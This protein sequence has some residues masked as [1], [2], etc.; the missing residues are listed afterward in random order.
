MLS[1]FVILAITILASPQSTAP[2]QT[3]EVS[4]RDR[5]YE[6]V[7]T[8][9]IALASQE[10]EQQLKA[11]PHD[12]EIHLL[13]INLGM[14]LLRAGRRP[15]GE[16][17]FEKFVRYVF[18]NPEH[19][20]SLLK[21][22]P[23]I[24]MNITSVQ[25]GVEPVTSE[26]LQ[27]VIPLLQKG[28]VDQPTNSAFSI[29]LTSLTALKARLLAR[30]EQ[31]VE[32]LSLINS[33]LDR[34]RSRW[35]TD[36]E[37]PDSWLRLALMLRSAA[38]TIG[39]D[40]NSALAFSFERTNVLNTGVSKF[41][42][43]G[44]LIKEAFNERLAQIKQYE[45][46]SPATALTLYDEADS[47][48]RKISVDSP[49]KKT[50]HSLRIDI[51]KSRQKFFREST[52]KKLIGSRVFVPECDWLNKKPVLSNLET[53]LTAYFFFTAKQPESIQELIKF[54]DYLKTAYPDVSA[55][56]MTHSLDDSFGRL[57]IVNRT[58]TITDENAREYRQ[59]MID[60]IVEPNGIDFPVGLLADTLPVADHFGFRNVPIAFFFD[61]G[62]C[63]KIVQGKDLLKE[64]SAY[65]SKRIPKK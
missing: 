62:I 43:A 27:G 26:L 17:E 3:D 54:N 10:L 15:E 40:N 50:L 20:Q 1:K 31:R 53:G 25:R 61:N 34:L 47:D 8:G 42:D 30:Q 36:P 51:A 33:E 16:Q 48:L 24:M 59:Q 19:S 57:P 35:R 14:G 65:L 39:S 38:E 23:R 55:V 32:S 21:H 64:L 9:K 4:A 46:T 2:S 18:N 63:Q 56:L 45:S 11:T 12:N 44:P 49:I 52:Q 41:M 13:R 7:N 6:L 28:V 60:Q 22:V 29:G 37:N 5:I 58:K